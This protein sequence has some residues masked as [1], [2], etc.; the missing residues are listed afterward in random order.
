MVV[1]VRPPMRFLWMVVFAACAHTP[2]VRSGSIDGDV[3]PSLARLELGVTASQMVDRPLEIHLALS[4]PDAHGAT[5]FAAGQAYRVFVDGQPA[6]LLR[7]GDA[8]RGAAIS[9]IMINEGACNSAAYLWRATE[10][11]APTAQT[12][13]TVEHAGH[14]AR[15]TFANLT[16]LRELRISPSSTSVRPGDRVALEWWPREDEWS[17]Y[18]AASSVHIYQPDELSVH[19]A[20]RV[21]LPRFTFTMPDVRPGPVKLDL[22]HPY[23]QAHPMIR[24]CEGLVRC[25]ASA[26]NGPRVLELV[27]LAR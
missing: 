8:S 7:D 24:A 21:D 16:T 19:A 25:T 13:V 11:F 14:T 1:A 27:V 20:V 15:A 3:D 26:Q 18:P 12:T 5:C 22:N 17:G 23:L 10:G 9:G 4:D 2:G 6:Q